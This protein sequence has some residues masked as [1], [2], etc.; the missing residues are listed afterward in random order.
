MKIEKKK[1]VI[2]CEPGTE[3][4]SAP[5]VTP[6]G[7]SVII[8]W[9]GGALA[10]YVTSPDAKLPLGPGLVEGGST[11]WVLETEAFPATFEGPVTYGVANPGT[12]DAS[13]NHG[14]TLGGSE[15]VSGE[16][17]RFSV[18]VDFGFHHTTVKWP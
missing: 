17:Y 7:E 12:L 13:E 1:P 8:D 2:G 3:G 6:D 5:S 16:C 10:L 4:A 15:F 9:D 18:V 11:Y 14:G